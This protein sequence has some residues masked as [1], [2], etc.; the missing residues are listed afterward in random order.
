MSYFE[1]QREQ[2]CTIHSL[3][4]AMGLKV[5]TKDEV[6]G[7]IDKLVQEYRE[8]KKIEISRSDEINYRKRFSNK[9]TSFF[10]A[11]IVWRA[12][13]DLGRIGPQIPIPGFSGAF[14]KIKNLPKPTP[15]HIIMLGVEPKEG[16]HAIAIR[17]GVIFDSL[18]SKPVPLTED[19]LKKSLR[20][21]FGAYVI[22]ESNKEAKHFSFLGPAYVF[23][24]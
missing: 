8:E 15:N 12:A 10:T 24:L 17:D 21:I 20:D 2:D 6:V 4:N 22:T 23:E 3:N 1:Q 9:R 14:A 7:Y 18:R 19:Q 11:E 5:I 16:H 13:Q